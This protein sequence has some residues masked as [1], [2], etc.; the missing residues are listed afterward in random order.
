[1]RH[2]TTMNIVLAIAAIAFRL[3]RPTMRAYAMPM[4]SSG[5]L[6]A[7][8]AGNLT[9]TETLPANP[10]KQIDGTPAAGIEV[11]LHVPAFVAASTLDAK[12]QHS[13]DGTTWVDALVFP[14]INAAGQVG[15]T[16]RRLSTPKKYVRYVMTVAGGGANFGAVQFGFEAGGEQAAW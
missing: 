15:E 6:R 14:Q 5:M 7:A 8:A 13:D 1:M 12:V 11:R 9:A 2:S 16:R 3:L 4:D 10:G